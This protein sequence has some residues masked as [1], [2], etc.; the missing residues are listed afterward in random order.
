MYQ[1]A[2]NKIVSYPLNN[3]NKK[4]SAS[5]RKFFVFP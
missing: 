3:V 2:T 4:L 5:H 1:G